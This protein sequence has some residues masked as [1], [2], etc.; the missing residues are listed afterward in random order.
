MDELLILPIALFCSVVFLAVGLFM[1]A[2]QWGAR[3]RILKK[4]ETDG[5]PVAV[6]EQ[7]APPLSFWQRFIRMTHTVGEQ[8]R[9]KGEDEGPGYR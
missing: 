2:K 3:R 1:Y 7:T 4:I 9:P 8:V 6:E 5:R